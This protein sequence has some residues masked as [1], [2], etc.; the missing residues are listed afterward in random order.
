MKK[1]IIVFL[2]VLMAFL[3]GCSAAEPSAA[4]NK[5]TQLDEAKQAAK[6]PSEATAD[7]REGNGKTYTIKSWRKNTDISIPNRSK[8]KGYPATK[9]FDQLTFVGDERYN[10][11]IL[12]TTAGLVLIDAM[13]PGPKYTNMIEQA[14]RDI[15]YDPSDVIAL[16]LTHGHPDHYG[17][18]NHWIHNYGT[19]VFLSEIDIETA[20]N[21]E[22]EGPSAPGT[23]TAFECDEVT[24]IEDMEEL[25][26]GDTT[27]KCVFTPGHS[28]GAMSFIFEVTDEGVPH[29]AG[30]WG[31]NGVP[32]DAEGL[33]VYEWSLDR[34]MEVC[35]EY[36]VD[37][38]ISNHPWVDMTLQRLD[39]LRNLTE[40][41]PNPFVIG[42][43][44][45][46]YYMQHFYYDHVQ[47]NRDALQ[48]GDAQQKKG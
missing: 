24:I 20:R 2:I 40:G 3:S 36:N 38:E 30:L 4:V 10:S 44:Q 42:E 7:Q 25:T 6:D 14:I 39:L 16:L 41:V 18:P 27:I 32:K 15:G 34:Y 28:P 47:R 48:N 23:S 37:V 45:C 46:K 22:P 43:E 1:K 9:M 19:E 35:D 29:M 11:F 12:E 8:M 31:G 17:S 26:F 21:F 5:P 13:Y 33:D